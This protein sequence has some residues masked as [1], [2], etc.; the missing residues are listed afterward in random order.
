MEESPLAVRRGQPCA[1]R[2]APGPNLGKSQGCD[3]RKTT[4]QTGSVAGG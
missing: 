2:A 1:R 3:T 4:E